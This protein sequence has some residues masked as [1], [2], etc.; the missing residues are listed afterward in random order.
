VDVE[1][2]CQH[3]V[4]KASRTVPLTI[5]A[6]AAVVLPVGLVVVAGLLD[7]TGSWWRK[8]ADVS[9][10][11]AAPAVAVVAAWVIVR[12]APGSPS[13]P[14]LA[15]T[16]GSISLMSAFDVV[17][18]SETFARPL[19][20]AS[21]VATF[22]T[23]L[24]PLTVAGLLGLLLVFPDRRLRGRF[25][26]AVPWAYAAATVLLVV[27]LWGARK[28]DGQVVR[29]PSGGFRF[30]LMIGGQ[31]MVL[32][33]LVAAIVSLVVRYR[34]GDDELHLRVRWL[35][36]AGVVVVALLMVGLVMSIGFAVS[37]EIAYAPLLIAIV[38]LVP[39]AV[40]IAV[41]RHDL[42]DIDRLLS[43]SAAWVVTLVLSAAAF[44]VVVL[45]VSEVL[46]RSSRLDVTA[47]A[48]VTA[49]VLLPLYR[50]VS[51]AVARV[52][53]R[54][55]FV[56]VARVERFAA[57]VRAGSREPE[58]IEVVLREAQGDPGLRIVLADHDSWV[59]VSGEA[60]DIGEALTL[61]FG[62]DP[63]SRI[64]ITHNSARARRRLTVLSRAAAVPIEVCRLRLGLRASR[65]RLAEATI[66][67]R[68][69]LE[70]DL[71]DGAQ[72]RLIATGM[73]LRAVQ[74]DLDPARSAEIDQ[75]I[76]ELEGT[77]AELR[78]L[79]Q[80]IR[81]SRL[82]DG[83]GAA[84]EAVCAATPIPVDLYVSALPVLDDVRSLSAYLVVSEAVTN[85]LKHAH[86]TRV[87]VRI[88][89]DGGRLFVEVSDDGVGGVPVNGVL[90]ILRDRVESVGGTV[91]ITSPPGIGTTITAVL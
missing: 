68:R 29:A 25:W 8:L 5:G 46:S 44:G 82:D 83:L 71:H 6:S 20:L 28:V 66:A 9:P 58:E 26:L 63:I 73:R 51:G 19:P 12:H 34:S 13:G 75:A 16:G 35:M 77:V 91:T 76:A 64:S 79:A 61:E 87:G 21:E 15:W 50:Y 48:F 65:A 62:G 18:E 37:L 40:A 69:R 3:S 52:V 31:L 33:C 32:A 43:D 53:D 78:Q 60:G 88:D 2:P 24:W 72:Q 57:E 27:A 67:E 7:P 41:V 80:G 47:A 81:P 55:R 54:D 11:L 42:F 1:V 56:A 39:V 84:L 90:T 22:S 45:G 10:E 74:R 89:E 59:D 70:R 30:A 36:L 4:V 86:A 23:G 14:A 17:A 85:V 38:V 49:L